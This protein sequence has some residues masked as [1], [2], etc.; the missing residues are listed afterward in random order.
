[1]RQL[2][3]SRPGSY[4]ECKVPSKEEKQLLLILV[5]ILVLLKGSSILPTLTNRL[6]K[7]EKFLAY[8]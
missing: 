5:V 8:Y 6:E 2:L 4:W 3:S 1:M 7:S